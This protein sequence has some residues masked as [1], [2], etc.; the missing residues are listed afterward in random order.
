[1]TLR[2]EAFFE[3]LRAERGAAANTVAAYENDLKD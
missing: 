2:I 3:K 1:M